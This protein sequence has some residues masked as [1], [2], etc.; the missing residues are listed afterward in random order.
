VCRISAAGIPKKVL[1]FVWTLNDK[2]RYSHAP[3]LDYAAD[4]L[5]PILENLQ[6]SQ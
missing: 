3:R 2:G 6:A 5:H 1:S 4:L